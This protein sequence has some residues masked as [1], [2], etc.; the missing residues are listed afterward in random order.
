M[1]ENLCDDCFVTV[2]GYE[3]DMGDDET[4]FSPATCDRCGSVAGIT[5]KIN[6]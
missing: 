4:T 3:P 2:H 6:V 1:P 5:F